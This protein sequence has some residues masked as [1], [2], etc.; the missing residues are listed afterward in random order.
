MSDVLNPDGSF[1]GIRVPQSVVDHSQF[2]KYKRRYSAYGGTDPRNNTDSMS[3]SVRDAGG[4]LAWLILN[5][6]TYKHAESVFSQADDPMWMDLLQAIP[7]SYKSPD[8]WIGEIT[9]A[10]IKNETALYNKAMSE[11][12]QLLRDYQNYITG[13]PVNQVQ[14]NQDAG[15]NMAVTGQGI[16]SQSSIAPVGADVATEVSNP[17]DIAANIVSTVGGF[18][19][20]CSQVFQTFQGAKLAKSALATQ[21]VQRDAIEQGIRQAKQNSWNEQQLRDYLFSAF[22]LSGDNPYAPEGYSNDN[23]DV[24]DKKRKIASDELT[25]QDNQ[26]AMNPFNNKGEFTVDTGDGQAYVAADEIFKSMSQFGLLE[27]YYKS[28]MNMLDKQIRSSYLQLNFDLE[29]EYYANER[30]ASNA[31]NAF[32]FDFFTSRSG[33]SEGQA[34]SNI[35]KNS[36]NI[37]YYQNLLSQIEYGFQEVKL[38][39]FQAMM[40]KGIEDYRYA[41]FVMKALYGVDIS[42]SKYYLPDY[43]GEGLIYDMTSGAKSAIDLFKGLNLL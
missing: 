22:G 4:E 10:N 8:T 5:S 41:P 1:N 24:H 11:I 12:N 34:T 14:Q 43:V 38:K 15:I 32:N 7:S 18:V 13:L 33:T 36:A 27:M 17:V 19:G 6:V 37:G 3:R 21:S 30:S 29:S 40:K 2:T 42:D 20:F 26:N 31:A 35:L 28:T 23:K 39:H 25:I 16:E 9:G